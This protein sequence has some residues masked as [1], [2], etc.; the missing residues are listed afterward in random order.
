M[1]KNPISINT[2]NDEQT[3]LFKENHYIYQKWQ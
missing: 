3:L 2:E 1:I